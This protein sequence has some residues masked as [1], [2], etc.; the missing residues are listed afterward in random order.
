MVANPNF[1][2]QSPDRSAN[3][4]P[5]DHGRH[6]GSSRGGSTGLPHW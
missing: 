2:A 4:L 6:S 5:L 1:R 3:V